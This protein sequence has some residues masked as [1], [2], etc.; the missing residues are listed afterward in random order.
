[1]IFKYLSACTESTVP[2]YYYKYSKQNFHLVTQSRGVLRDISCLHGHV[3]AGLG[4][5]VTTSIIICNAN[6]PCFLLVLAILTVPI[7]QTAMRMMLLPQAILYLHENKGK[8]LHRYRW[9]IF[10]T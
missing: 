2:F 1:M 7:C 10:S 4:K 9:L 3:W 5:K 6:L 8:Q